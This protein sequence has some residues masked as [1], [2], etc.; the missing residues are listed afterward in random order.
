M[1]LALA[2]QSSLLVRPVYD[3]PEPPE[4]RAARA[5]VLIHDEVPGASGKG[6]RTFEEALQVAAEL[7]QKLEAGTSFSELALQ[8]D[9]SP[10]RKLGSHLGAFPQGIFAPAIDS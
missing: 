10:H 7:T 1:I 4:L 5:I 8:Y 3:E 2:L 6:L 9:E